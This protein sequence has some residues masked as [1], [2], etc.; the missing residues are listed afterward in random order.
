MNF[1]MWLA[2]GIFIGWVASKFFGKERSLMGYLS[3]GIMGSYFG[4]WLFHQFNIEAGGAFG[5]L[6]TSIS[7]S[8]ILIFIFKTLKERKAAR[9]K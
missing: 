7:G 6:F 8:I 9:Q 3:I 1:V 2:T 5:S 4:G